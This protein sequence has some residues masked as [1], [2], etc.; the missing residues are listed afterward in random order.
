MLSRRRY[1][2]S[3]GIVGGRLNSLLIVLVLVASIGGVIYF[4]RDT[5]I[6]PKN[7]LSQLKFEPIIPSDSTVLW[8]DTTTFKYDNRSEVFSYIMS[9]RVNTIKLTV[10]QQVTPD[11]IVDIPDAFDKL[12]NSIKP[13]LTFDS[14]FGKVSVGTPGGT[15]NEVAVMNS[16]G[17]L[18]FISSEAKIAEDE[19]RGIINSF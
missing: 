11:E 14:Q 8:V 9:T 2:R 15:K 19:W 17:V 1:S 6:V 4:T 7:I 3:R 13:Y 16:K 10:T 18:I 12:Q 5:S